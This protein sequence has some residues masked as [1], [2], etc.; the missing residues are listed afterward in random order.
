LI[1]ALPPA[2]ARLDRRRH[3]GCL[4]LCRGSRS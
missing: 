1:H 2:C 3:L 4:E